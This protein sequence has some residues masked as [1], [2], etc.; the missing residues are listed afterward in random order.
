[1][2]SLLP[3]LSL[4]LSLSLTH[5]HTHTNATKPHLF[6]PRAAHLTVAHRRATSHIAT[7]ANRSRTSP[8]S[9]LQFTFRR[10]WMIYTGIVLFVNIN[11]PNTLFPKALRI[12]ASNCSGNS[13]SSV[14][15]ANL[16][17]EPS[18]NWVKKI[19]D[20][21]R[22]LEKDLPVVNLTLI[23]LP[24]LTKVSVEGQSDTIVEDIEN[25]VHSYVEKVN[26]LE[27]I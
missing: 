12:S 10:T 13:N 9:R 5:T 19:Q 7:A 18:K 25:V 24:G 1:M 21:W 11:N 4:S 26:N 15:K 20:E 17:S 27:D 23:D 8:L 14:A 2:G 3:S 22:I 16:L 6:S